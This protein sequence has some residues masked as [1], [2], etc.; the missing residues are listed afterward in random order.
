MRRKPACRKKPLFRTRTGDP[1]LTMRSETV[2]VGCHRLRIHYSCRVRP[3]PFAIGCHQLRPLGSI[4]ASCHGRA[5]ERRSNVRTVAQP[6][7]GQVD[8]AD[9]PVCRS[10]PTVAALRAL[11]VRHEDLA[12]VAKEVG[13]WPI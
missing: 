13:M 5:A 10:A 2:A 11:Q 9:P 3:L 12:A 8:G 4:N 7:G 1:L 6:A